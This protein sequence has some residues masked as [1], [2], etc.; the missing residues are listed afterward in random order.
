MKREKTTMLSVGHPLEI[1]LLSQA[2]AA[3]GVDV[4]VLVDVDIGDR[5]TGIL[6]G[7]PGAGTGRSSSPSTSG[8]TFAECSRTLD[9][10]HTSLVGKLARSRRVKRWGNPSRRASC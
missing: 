7:Q 4:D 9:T 3:A 8:C 10:P 5:R 2:A 6:P 1:E